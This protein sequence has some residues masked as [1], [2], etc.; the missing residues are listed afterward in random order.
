MDEEAIGLD[1]AVRRASA[2][3]PG[4]EALDDSEY[5]QCRTSDVFCAVEP[6]ADAT[7]IPPSDRSGFE[8]ALYLMF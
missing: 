6:K 2:A 3:R 5:E 1:A 7:A 4:R 8:F